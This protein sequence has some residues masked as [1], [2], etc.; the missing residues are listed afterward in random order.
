MSSVT[1]RPPGVGPSALPDPP[2]DLGAV[3]DEELDLT[4]SL[5]LDF[6]NTVVRTGRGSVDLLADPDHFVSWLRHL[7]DPPLLALVPRDPPGLR[8]LT[9]EARA[10]REAL[11]ELFHWVTGSGDDLSSQAA[12]TVDRALRAASSVHRLGGHDGEPRSRRS[13]EA[14]P[15]AADHASTELKRPPA[16]ETAFEAASP[17]GVLTPIA[18][19]AL[20]VVR[21]ADPGRLRSCAA[22]DCARWFVD[23]SRGGQRRWCSMARCGNRAKAARYRRRHGSD[24]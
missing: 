8:T 10:L 14:A 15:G 19:S 20:R 13:R 2:R 12:H 23:T 11:A 1:N 9:T 17:L 6:L 21:A 24:G 22:D 5:G 4:G 16:V 7:D 3:S 18:L